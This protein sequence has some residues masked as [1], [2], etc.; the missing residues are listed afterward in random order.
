MGWGTSAVGIDM[1]VKNLA[2]MS[3]GTVIEPKNSYR[4]HE[5]KLKKE[6]K[7]LSK[8]VKFSKNWCKQKKKVQRAHRKI[9]NVRKDFLHKQSTIISKKHAT[10]VVED[11]KIKNMSRSAKGTLE[12]PGKNVRAKSGLNKS[13]LDQGWGMF[14]EMLR[15]KLERLGGKL[16]QVPPQ[17]TSQTCSQCGY[18]NKANRPSQAKFHCL[19]CG[20][21][22]NADVNA[23]INILHRAGLTTPIAVEHPIVH[24][25]QKKLDPNFPLL[26]WAK[27]L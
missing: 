4:K 23:A 27:M 8:K 10:I 12:Q 26:D 7:K 20:Y 22:N 14:R 16:I 2:T 11:L 6:Q 3:D 17:Y 24:P 18:V 15:Y 1:G 5:D 13:I 25:V 9:A 21:E 19:S